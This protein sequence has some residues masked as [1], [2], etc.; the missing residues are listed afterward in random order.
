LDYQLHG[1]GTLT[2]ADA[3]YKGQF[4]NSQM[5][6]RGVYEWNDG[7]RYYIGMYVRDKKEGLGIYR[8]KD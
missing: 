8:F 6:G 3:I 1:Q 4:F 2:L 5:H 7:H